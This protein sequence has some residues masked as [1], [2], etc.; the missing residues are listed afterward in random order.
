MAPSFNDLPE[1]DGH[2]SE[3]EIDFSGLSRNLRIFF[4][5]WEINSLNGQISQNNMKLD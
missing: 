2:E 4:T 1:D 5:I 3:E